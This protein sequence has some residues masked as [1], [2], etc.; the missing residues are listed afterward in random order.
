[1]GLDVRDLVRCSV[2]NRALRELAY[3]HVTRLDFTAAPLL[4]QTWW[5]PDLLRSVTSAS[6]H[7]S[8]VLGAAQLGMLRSLHLTASN[9][10]QLQPLRALRHLT[11]LYVHGSTAAGLRHLPSLHSLA[12]HP[13]TAADLQ[14]LQ[15][16]TQLSA[17]TL[18]TDGLCPGRAAGDLSQPDFQ[19]LCSLAS[20]QTLRVLSMHLYLMGGAEHLS[21]CSS[22][23]RLDL[24][25]R[26]CDCWES[27]EDGESCSFA[28]L[29]QLQVVCLH[30]MLHE[31]FLDHLQTHQIS[32]LQQL[33]L[34]SPSPFSGDIEAPDIRVPL[35]EV[36]LAGKTWASIEQ[37][38]SNL[39]GVHRRAHRLQRPSF[40]VLR[41]SGWPAAAAPAEQE[42]S[43]Q[44]SLFLLLRHG[45]R[46]ET[47]AAG[48]ETEYQAFTLPAELAALEDSS[49]D[50]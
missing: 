14:A 47:A 13:H 24:E 6:V 42:T 28:S 35:L 36:Q 11:E 5:R 8:A 48:S 30:R 1:M 9:V 38:L 41:L 33:I 43:I 50:E 12:A 25:Y 18:H 27:F 4:G 17:L 37:L 32:G 40:T 22:L 23:R 34:T 15:H 26:G 21:S 10:V 44:T 7:G 29:Q 49:E 16:F 20:L 31:L 46:V 2:V 39:A 3:A 19:G 45:V